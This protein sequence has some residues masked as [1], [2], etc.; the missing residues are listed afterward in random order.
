MNFSVKELTYSRKAVENGI[1]NVPGTSELKNIMFLITKL[2]E[3]RSL[4]GSPMLISSGYRCA[5]LNKLVGGSASSFHTKGLAVDFTCPG[6]GNTADVVKAIYN[7]GIEYD[8]LILEYPNKGQ[9]SWVHIGFN[10]VVKYACNRF[11]VGL[12]RRFFF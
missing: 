12:C 7:S 3:V 11:A 5:A 4:L 8:Q 2:E 9:R 6:Y 1:S 10:T